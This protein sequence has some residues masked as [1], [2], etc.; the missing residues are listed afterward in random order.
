MS[1]RYRGS[2]AL[3]RDGAPLVETVEDVLEA[4]GRPVRPGPRA[5][6]DGAVDGADRNPR[7]NPLEL[8]KLERQMD[9][10]ELYSLDQLI[11]RTGLN[12]PAVLAEI[13]ALEV[14]G[15][16]GRLPGGGFVRLDNS[17]I[18]GGDG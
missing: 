3:I 7:S 6:D 11:D 12:G 8:S 18:G 4:L 5:R 16:V 14:A 13:G 1:G 17:G 9:I 2:H 10:G 15:R